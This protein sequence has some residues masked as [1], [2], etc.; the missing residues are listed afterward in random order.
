M[1]TALAMVMA[2]PGRPLEARRLEVPPPAPGGALLE[3]VASEV[4]GTDVHL[5]HGRLAGVPYPIIPGHVSCGRVLETNGTLRDVEG[6]TIE[7]GRLVTFYDVYGTCG[8]CWH[9]LVAKAA[10]R[11]PHRRVYGITTSAVDGL[12][13]G[14]AERIE[15]RPG[16]RVLPLPDGIDAHDFMGGGCGLPTGFHAVERAGLALGDTVVVQG[17]G[18]VGLNA[19]V[20]A[21]LA[22]AL[23]VF[24]V[25]APAARLEAARRLGAE[26]VLDVTATPSAEERVRWVRER[27]RGRGADVVI[28]A[29]GNPAAVGEGLDMVRDAGRYVVVGQYTDAGDVTLNPHRQMNRKHVTILGCW[30]YEYTHLHRSVQLMAR[31]NA[32]FRWARLITREY[33]LEEA[34]QALQD[35]ERLAVVKA[36]IRPTRG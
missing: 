27:T 26:D 22:G 36:L 23:R 19:L 4:C 32:R 30:G 29:S 35:M 31:H 2:A 15:L 12:L 33:R 20:F 6:Q 18:P 1:L 8:S 14:W 3:T 10:T 5:H 11:C 9:C 17:S 21:S 7:V 34:G 28:E 25:G 13:G 16:V 24:V